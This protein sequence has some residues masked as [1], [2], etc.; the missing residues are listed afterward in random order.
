MHK[1][2]I[3]PGIVL[4]TIICFAAINQVS[5]K[6]NKIDLI[7][8]AQLKDT[9]PPSKDEQEVFDKVEIEA[10]VDKDAWKKHLEKELLPAIENAAKKGMKPG[11]YI[12]MVRF[13]IERD[14]S[15]S[16]AKAMNNPGFG[17]AK[18]S[19]NVIKSGPR[20]NAGEI[21]GRKIR[22]YHT[23]PITYVISE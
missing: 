17:L 22:S 8:K 19:V 14:G 18:A 20:W 2:F 1:S 11:H 3:I 9:V 16:E 13:L 7:R 21:N 6:P 23:Q 12:V 4:L 5:A 15:I 10:S